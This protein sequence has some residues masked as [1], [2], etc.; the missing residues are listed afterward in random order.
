MVALVMARR[1]V[2]ATAVVIALV[3]FLAPLSAIGADLTMF[4]VSVTLHR[5]SYAVLKGVNVRA[6]PR[7]SG[8]RVSTLVMGAR[9][10]VVA[11]TK[12]GNWL[13]VGKRGKP[14]GF[15]YAPVMMPLVDGDLE[16]DIIGAVDIADGG[17]CAYR[18]EYEGKSPIEGQ[19]FQV[20]DYA[21]DVTCK[22]AIGALRFPMQMFMTETPY[23]FSPSRRVFQI[24]VD[25]REDFHAKEDMLTAIFLFDLDKGRITLDTVTLADYRR[26]QKA[27]PWQPATAVRQALTAALE[28]ALAAWNTEAWNDIAKKRRKS[29]DSAG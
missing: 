12:D 3:A 24:N 25:L 23:Q 15:V 16:D 27:T 22:S 10:E 9:V 18:L 7:T 19:P 4:G 29:T 21:V 5:G 11:R 1:M 6:Q 2:R 20:F 8:D 28:M 13:V 26:D 17:R 14:L